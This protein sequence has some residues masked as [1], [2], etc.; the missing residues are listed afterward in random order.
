MQNKPLAF[1]LSVMFSYSIPFWILLYLFY[2]IEP[3][4]ERSTYPWQ[5]LAVIF[6][7]FIIPAFG[8][9][10][11]HALY[12]LSGVDESTAYKRT[13]KT[14]RSTSTV[15]VFLFSL[16]IIMHFSSRGLLSNIHNVILFSLALFLFILF[17]FLVASL[18]GYLLFYLF[19]HIFLK[20]NESN[21]L[22][23]ETLL[24][25]HFIYFYLLHIIFCL[26]FLGIAIPHMKIGLYKIAFLSIPSFLTT[27]CFTWCS[28]HQYDVSK[29]LKFTTFAEVVGCFTTGLFLYLMGFLPLP[30]R[31][32]SSTI[33]LTMAYF[34]VQIAIVYIFSRVVLREFPGI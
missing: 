13:F 18:F 23:K 3:P 28:Y 7:Y 27:I 33:I 9:G 11:L 2:P 34:P 24:F 17:L 10:F 25:I 15:F 26:P 31:D 12:Y 6:V 16:P 32:S 22:S 5:N 14:V 8:F 1:I 30:P 4:L 20:S 29:T 19:K 21:L